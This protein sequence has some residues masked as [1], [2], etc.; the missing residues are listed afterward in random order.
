MIVAGTAGTHK[1]DTG[2]PT[3]RAALRPRGPS[4]LSPGWGRG[5]G[6]IPILAEPSLTAKLDCR[7]A[8]AARRACARGA[9]PTPVRGS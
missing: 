7:W 8:G 5:R 6:P 2:W 9:R 4:R 1:R 3:G